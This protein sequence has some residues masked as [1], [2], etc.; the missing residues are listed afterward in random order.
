[1]RA[2]PALEKDTADAQAAVDATE[3][4]R[5]KQA[6]T[7]NKLE[8][9][10]QQELGE[11]DKLKRQKAS[12]R[13]D[14][15]LRKKLASSLETA[16]Q[17][18]TAT[19]RLGKLDRK[20]ARQRKALLAAIDAELAAGATGTRKAKLEASRGVIAAKVRKKKA[21]KIVIPDDEID[22][23][24]DP[25]ELDAQVRALE[26][27]EAELERQLAVLDK[28]VKKLR[29]QAE[30]RKQHQRADEMASRDEGNPRRTSGSGG[31]DGAGGESAPQADTAEDDG[32]PDAGF[33][34]DAVI[35]SDIVDADTVDALRK[36]SRSSD[37]D[38]K[39]DAAAK[40]RDQVERRKKALAKRRKEI[41]ARA[42]ALRE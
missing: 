5:A 39:A 41:E 1:V 31:R 21:K 36:A 14:R 35:L 2:D 28:Q 25:E 13:R 29:K 4:A 38:A 3:K 20:L 16:K 19:D 27:T 24:A 7:I 8:K 30:L 18:A 37:P 33:E 42:R 23:L 6:Q 9:R 40:A 22:P 11:L 32:P 15:Q 10:Y 26:E 34:D 12:W 17:L